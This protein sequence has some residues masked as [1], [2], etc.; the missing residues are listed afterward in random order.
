MKEFIKIGLSRFTES[1]FSLVSFA[2]VINFPSRSEITA[3]L[4]EGRGVVSIAQTD[5]GVQ[6]RIPDGGTANISAKVDEQS[7]DF[8]VRDWRVKLSGRGGDGWVNDLPG[9]DIH[10]ITPGISVKL[11]IPNTEA[12]LVRE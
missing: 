8:G 9:G 4:I 6:V 11:P 1:L 12:T 7:W 10:L 2:V 5:R 3:K